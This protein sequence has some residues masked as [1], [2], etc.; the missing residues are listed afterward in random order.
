MGSGIRSG[1][2]LK[3]TAKSRQA[4]DVYLNL[5]PNRSHVK[6]AEKL[7]KKGLKR[8]AEWSS[9]FNWVQRAAEFDDM[10]S[11]IAAEQQIAEYQRLARIKAE[12]EQRMLETLAELPNKILQRIGKVVDGPT[13]S[14]VQ[15]PNG[16]KHV[17]P[18]QIGRDVLSFTIA[19]QKLLEV[20]QQL[21]AAQAES[22]TIEE[23]YEIIPWE[24]KATE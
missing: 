14:L 1:E 18:V 17:K 21:E 23:V 24:P 20:R 8:I 12:N 15:M 16:N 4:F 2:T 7:G 3:E 19:W 5:G 9:K 10:N 6:V 13:I 11:R 22:S